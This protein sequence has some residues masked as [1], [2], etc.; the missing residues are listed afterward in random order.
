MEL[1]TWA[2]KLDSLDQDP[3]AGFNVVSRELHLKGWTGSNT[4]SRSTVMQHSSQLGSGSRPYGAKLV[5]IYLLI[6]SFTR[7]T[8]SVTVTDLQGG[9]AYNIILTKVETLLW[10]WVPNPYR[11]RI[12]GPVWRAPIV[13][14]LGLLVCKLYMKLWHC[15]S[16]WESCH[17]ERPV[18]HTENVHKGNHSDNH[19]EIFFLTLE[20]T[21][22]IIKKLKPHWKIFSITHFFCS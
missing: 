5:L 21:K 7:I 12:Q 8:P 16:H 1:S 6:L 18:N 4:L 19:T 17:T 10:I 11:I 20:D 13:E 22:M 3:R 9:P 2:L 14:G 15:K